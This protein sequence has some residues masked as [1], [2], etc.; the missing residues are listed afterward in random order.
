MVK[1][2]NLTPLFGVRVE[3]TVIYLDVVTFRLKALELRDC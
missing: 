1:L 3:P 2:Y